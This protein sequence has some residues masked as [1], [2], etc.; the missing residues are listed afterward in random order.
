M[1][2]YAGITRIRLWVKVKTSLSRISTPSNI[3]FD[4]NTNTKKFNQ[5]FFIKIKT[6]SV[7]HK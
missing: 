2:T 4:Y 7:K 3:Y 1:I 6:F 5:N